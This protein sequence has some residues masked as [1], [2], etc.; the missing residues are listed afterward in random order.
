MLGQDVTLDVADAGVQA[1]VIRSY[2][3]SCAA[4]CWPGCAPASLLQGP[5]AQ[6][7]EHVRVQ[8]LLQP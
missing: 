2:A 5:Q 4:R 6:G 7:S 1:R 8:V 3:A